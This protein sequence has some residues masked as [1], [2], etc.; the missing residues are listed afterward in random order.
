[1]SAELIV[2][3]VLNKPSI[4]TLV[5]RRKALLQLPQNSQYPAIVYSVV[6][7]LPMPNLAYQLGLQRSQARV[8]FNPIATSISTIQA[9]HA[10]IKAE[11]DYLHH[12]R[13]AGK[14][15]ISCR[16]VLRGPV[17]KDNDTG[18]WTQPYDYLLHFAE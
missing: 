1:M 14:L 16:L 2:S 4:M 6:D 17:D 18:L 7:V 13:V 15:L 5:G 11:F 9:I 3:S 12:V 10:A 8:Q